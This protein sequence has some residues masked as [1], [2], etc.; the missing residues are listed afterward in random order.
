MKGKFAQV[1]VCKKSCAMTTS[2]VIRPS[3]AKQ[4]GF[5]PPAGGDWIEIGTAKA[6][7][8]SSA[9]RKVA[10]HLNTKAKGLLAKAGPAL[11]AHGLQILG[12][13]EATTTKGPSQRGAAAWIVTVAWR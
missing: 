5:K 10:V 3:V 2:V 7:L 9:S 6:R 8:S 13:V 4:L 11:K 1:V 12:R